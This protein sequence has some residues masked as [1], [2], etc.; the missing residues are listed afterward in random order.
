MNAPASDSFWITGSPWSYGN[1]QTANAV[2]TPI[3]GLEMEFF[4]SSYAKTTAS[5]AFF[6]N[7]FS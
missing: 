4:I 7:I 1:S 5:L 3:A 6:Y 2:R